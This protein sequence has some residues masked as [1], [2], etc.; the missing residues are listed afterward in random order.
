[1]L[2]GT[3]YVYQGEELGMTNGVF[4]CLDDFRDV[5]ALRY[6]REAVEK[7]ED[8]E[9]VLAGMRATGRDNARTPVQWDDGP[10]AGFTDAVPWIGVTPNYKEINAAS[11]VGDP[12]SVYSYYRALADIRHALPVIADGAYERIHTASPAIFAYRRTLDEAVATILVNLSS[13]PASLGEAACGVRG[14]L[15]LS[16]RDL[17]EAEAEV[18][19]ILGKWEARVYLA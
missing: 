17:S 2:R 6:Y 14:V 12:G 5:E 9:S 18:P 15:I 10:N 11:Q 1:M 19:E 13:Q 8:P 4:D 7:G 16:N 3:P